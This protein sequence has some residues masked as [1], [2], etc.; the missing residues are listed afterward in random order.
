MIGHIP[1]V[2]RIP[3]VEERKARSRDLVLDQWRRL[4]FLESE[5][6]AGRGWL[7]EVMRCV[8][9]I[10]R[11]EF[12]LAEVYAFELQVLRDGGYLEFLGRG[13]YRLRS[14]T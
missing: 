12:T 4:A 1:A 13:I 5:A 9:S 6:V 14:V 3:I 11:I 2:G 8:E 7:V 10:G